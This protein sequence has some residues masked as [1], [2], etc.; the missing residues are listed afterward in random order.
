MIISSD[1]TTARPPLNLISERDAATML[2]D[3]ITIAIWNSAAA[4][5][6]LGSRSAA[7]SRLAYHSLALASSSFL[8]SPVDGSL[9]YRSARER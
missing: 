8:P 9:S 2:T 1:A 7:R 3:P 4:K 6:K 5:S